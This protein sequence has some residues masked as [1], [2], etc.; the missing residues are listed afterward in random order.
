MGRKK[1]YAKLC[2]GCKLLVGIIAE[3]GN[4]KLVAVL[5]YL[6][7][8]HLFDIVCTCLP[9]YLAQGVCLDYFACYYHCV[10]VLI[11]S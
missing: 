11:I 10:E 2:K 3:K 1:G 6:L 7:D 8:Y 9:C 4:N 5:A